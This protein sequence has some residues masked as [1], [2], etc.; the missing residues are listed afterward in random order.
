MDRTRSSI[1]AISDVPRNRVDITLRGKS[2]VDYLARPAFKLGRQEFPERPAHSASEVTIT[3]YSD[4][5]ARVRSAWYY[6]YSSLVHGI[7]GLLLSAA[8]SDVEFALACH[9][10]GVPANLW[11]CLFVRLVLA[12]IAG[13][14]SSEMRTPPPA[15][16]SN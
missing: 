2:V 7:K 15:G 13:I 11:L 9:A 12:C 10:L 3:L 8:T 1:Q 5:V 6:I 16:S 14:H 4:E